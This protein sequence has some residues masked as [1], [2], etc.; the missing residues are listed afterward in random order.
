MEKYIKSDLKIYK[1][2]DIIGFENPKLVSKQNVLVENITN[3]TE[4]HNIKILYIAN[5]IK[6]SI[7]NQPVY[8]KLYT[9]DV[10]IEFEN[11][12]LKYVNEDIII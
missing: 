5:E 3:I 7:G 2:L 4:T 12:K 11:K 6:K 1:N 9:S 8:L 10:G